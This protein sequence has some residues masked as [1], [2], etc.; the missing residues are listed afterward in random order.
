V[1]AL[2]CVAVGEVRDTSLVVVVAAAAA[3]AVVGVDDL[4]AEHRHSFGL[5]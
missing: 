4:I 2:Q 1:Q 3:A 5:R